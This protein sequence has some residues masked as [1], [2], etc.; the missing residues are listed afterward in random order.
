MLKT[1]KTATKALV[2]H[3]INE[4][5]I[6]IDNLQ[7]HWKG[8]DIILTKPSCQSMRINH[9]SKARCQDKAGPTIA[10]TPNVLPS[11]RLGK[12]IITSQQ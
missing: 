7:G 1:K 12:K 8:V 3:P 11:S 10:P 6:P 2:V 5:Q 4:I 9:L